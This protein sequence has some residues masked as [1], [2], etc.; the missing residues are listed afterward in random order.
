MPSCSCGQM[1]AGKTVSQV[2]AHEQLEAENHNRPA[3]VINLS[4]Q[5]DLTR[6]RDTNNGHTREKGDQGV[7]VRA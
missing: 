1:C 6:I 4:P 5:V 3:F 7:L 2:L